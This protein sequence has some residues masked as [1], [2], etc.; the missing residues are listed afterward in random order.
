MKKNH[1]WSGL[2][3][4]AL[5]AGEVQVKGSMR[6]MSVITT[7]RTHSGERRNLGVRKRSRYDGTHT[8][9]SELKITLAALQQHVAAMNTGTAGLTARVTYVK[10]ALNRVEANVN[11]TVPRSHV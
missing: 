10:T 11:A 3:V 9:L 4:T 6:N 8:L 2:M 7:A 5:V 1:V